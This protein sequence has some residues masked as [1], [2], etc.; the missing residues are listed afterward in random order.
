VPQ[1]LTTKELAEH[2]KVTTQT[3][4]RWRVKGMPHIKLN[5][6]N[7]RYELPAVME[8]IKGENEEGK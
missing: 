3:I 6:Q 5:A 8:W 7:C 4:W 1:L 2:F